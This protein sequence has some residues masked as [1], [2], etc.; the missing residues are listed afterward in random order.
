MGE[1]KRETD[2]VPG[3]SVSVYVTCEGFSRVI[4]YCFQ[5]YLSPLGYLSL[6]LL[7]EDTGHS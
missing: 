6:R 2:T 1:G 7:S 4:T 5:G 3:V